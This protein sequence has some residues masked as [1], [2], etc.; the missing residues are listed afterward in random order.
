MNTTAV[1]IRT[2]LYNHAADYAKRHNTSIDNLVENYILTLLAI[3]PREYGY[4]T[5]NNS[6]KVD[7]E[8]VSERKS[9]RNSPVADATKRLLPKRRVKILD[10]YKPLLEQRLKEKYEGLS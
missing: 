6:T 10:D 5:K 7:K 1:N 4:N 8:G 2:D 9:W 3:M